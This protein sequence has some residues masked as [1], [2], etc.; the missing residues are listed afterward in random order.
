M[1][2]EKMLIEESESIL[3]AMQ[4]LDK[5]A[6]KILFVGEN[7]IL[8]AAL[9]DGDIRRWILK[10]GSLDALVKEAANYQ[11]KYIYEQ[12]KDCIQDFMDKYALDVVPIVDKHHMIV[13]VYM[14][15]YPKAHNLRKQINIP[16][17][18][19]AGGK[20]TR[21]YP[22]T[23][24]L[25]KP[26]IPIDDIPI[27]ERIINSFTEYGCMEYYM[28]VN[29]KKNMIKA[30]FNEIDKR[31]KI[32]YIEELEE[33][34]LGTGGGLSLLKGKLKETFFL[35]NCDILIDEDLSKMYEMHKVKGHD[36]TMICS[37][38]NFQ[39]PY[40][41]VEV[42]ADGTIDEMK[43]KPNF[44]FL[45]NTG[46][47]IVEPKVLDEIEENIV[48]SFPDIIKKCRE[49]GMKIGVYPISGK[50]W[51]DMGQIDELEKMRERLKENKNMGA[52]YII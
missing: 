45:T 36:I 46:V 14:S 37:L 44:S 27:A 4:K 35:T 9:T 49:R 41:V 3:G 11:P 13:D 20:G 15:R 12:D 21:L 42:A 6:T 38:L 50:S 43:E 26:L 5:V 33:L 25:P 2:I 28:I 39:V 23:K 19:M 51:L 40:G 32:Y 30:Y 7:G 18:M 8:K 34:P 17:V 52:K 47:Y 16:V 22:Y 1:E 29:H 24:I 48:I 10:G 31:Y